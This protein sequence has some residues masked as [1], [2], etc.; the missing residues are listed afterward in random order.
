MRQTIGRAELEVL[1]YITDRHP[2]TVR[3]VAEFLAATKGQTRTTALNMMER[4]R[5]KGYLTREKIEGVYH[6]SPSQSRG[7]LARGL[8]RE[9]IQGALGGSLQPFVAYLTEE[10][11][12]TDAQV[13]EL[14]RLVEALDS[15]RKEEPR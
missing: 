2:I 15:R 9:F 5:E 7:Q 4:L 13:E 6:Y 10:A 3:A 12:L 8:V 14:K 11:E 1:R